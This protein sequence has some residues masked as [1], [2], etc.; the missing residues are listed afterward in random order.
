MWAL[1]LATPPE[2]A[3]LAKLLTF[4]N[5]WQGERLQEA[6]RAVCRAGR[7]RGPQSGTKPSSPP[8]TDQDLAA[9]EASCSLRGVIGTYTPHMQRLL[10]SGR[11]LLPRVQ[12]G[13]L[14]QLQKAGEA[15]GRTPV[16]AVGVPPPTYRAPPH[17]PPS[18]R[19]RCPP[20]RPQAPTARSASS[21]AA[22]TTAT[23]TTTSSPR[24]RRGR[25][26]R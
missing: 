26:R 8:L 7:S 9:L 22:W 23:R 4:A 14:A 18:D 24:S 11:Q 5:G 6:D 3:I 13:G 10:S 2:D 12:Q 19:G 20:A 1:T 17:R 21:A 25:R 16:G 15:E